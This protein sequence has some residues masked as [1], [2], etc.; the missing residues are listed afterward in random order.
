M[1]N[2]EVCDGK[3]RHSIYAFELR[4]IGARFRHI[5]TRKTSSQGLF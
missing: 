5:I 4:S 3:V 1:I 2:D